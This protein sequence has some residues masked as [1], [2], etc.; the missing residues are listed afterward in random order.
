MDNDAKG[1]SGPL[2]AET[3]IALGQKSI[4]AMADLT[5]RNMDVMLAVA[6]VT[7]QGVQ[8][9]VSD[10]TDFS[11][12]S[13]ER[14]SMTARAMTTITSPADLI[15]LQTEFA[16]AQFEAAR[17]QMMKLSNSMFQTAREQLAAQAALAQRDTGGKAAP[18]PPRG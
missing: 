18:K 12:R 13:L 16:Q 1:P 7:T 17:A 4:D 6:E 2:S 10:M 8:A 9:V 15:R 5:R 14:T 11:R 3:A